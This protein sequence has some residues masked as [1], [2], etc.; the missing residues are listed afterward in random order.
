MNLKKH[1]FFSISLF[2]LVG[3]VF[4]TYSL[5]FVELKN[6]G[7]F[8]IIVFLTNAFLSIYFLLNL[9]HKDYTFN[10]AFWV[11][12]L[13][14]LTIIPFMQYIYDRRP[15][16]TISSNTF[17][18]TIYLY[19]NIFILLWII[20]YFLG[21]R[22]R[23]RF[24][25]KNSYKVIHIKLKLSELIFV[26]TLTVFLIFL[27]SSMRGNAGI[28]TIQS[29]R[30]LTF[31]ILKGM[32]AFGLL[33]LVN[34]YR[35]TH[36]SVLFVFLVIILILYFTIS[37][38]IG[39]G[40]RHFLAAVLFGLFFTYYKKLNSNIYFILM[41]LFALIVFP[42][43]G[44]LRNSKTI[45]D[46]DMSRSIYTTIASGDFDTYTMF[47]NIIKFVDINGYEYGRQ[48]LGALFYFVPRSFWSDKPIG[49]GAYVAE[50]FNFS[51]T[52]A[53]A[54]L[55]GEF[56]INFGLFGIIFMGFLLGKTIRYIDKMYWDNINI[57][58]STFLYFV[59]PFLMMFFFFM[60]R[61]DLL[62]GIAFMT[63]FIAPSYLI[64][65]IV[66]S[67]SLKIQ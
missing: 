17:D 16:T 22:S 62:S 47:M 46:I 35:L 23:V 26:Y 11:F 60:L 12:N 59:Y 38:N 58:Q 2:F 19:A 6:D 34:Q 5:Y 3:V 21:Y 51:F 53:S 42:F 18:D 40:G 29:I 37:I 66:K 36:K 4:F 55:I 28:E 61:G 43:I 39:G 67:K 56:Y 24:P 33:L 8:V 7:L 32:I 44:Q 30:L 1:I 49:T 64:Y 54:P 52:N 15:L 31:T 57:N 20:S 27:E 45:E 48:L 63:G 14:F 10:K 9:E 13:I 25:K 50:Y 41:L 65:L